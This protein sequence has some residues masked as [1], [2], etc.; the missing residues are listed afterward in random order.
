MFDLYSDK[1]KDIQL[2]LGFNPLPM[3]LE[4]NHIIKNLYQNYLELVKEN[5]T[6]YSKEFISRFLEL[7]SKKCTSKYIKLRLKY[8]EMVE[9]KY[10]REDHVFYVIDEITRTKKLN[11]SKEF[12]SNKLDIMLLIQDKKYSNFRLT[13]LFEAA[14]GESVAKP[15]AQTVELVV[16]AAAQTVEPVAAAAAPADKAVAPA[17][18]KAAHAAGGAPRK[19]Y[20]KTEEHTV[21]QGKQRAIYL[22]GSRGKKYV[23][24]EGKYVLLSKL[25]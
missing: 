20:T 11:Q 18:E 4:T 2:T 10:P 22:G 17:I 3:D 21:I 9:T 16:E 24:H 6:S 7:L 1:K 23:K 25:L 19:K 5:K 15:A 14:A 12:E 8:D 13:V